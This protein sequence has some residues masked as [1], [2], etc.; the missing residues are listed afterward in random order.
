MEKACSFQC[1]QARTLEAAR[2]AV[3]SADSTRAIYAVP[4]QLSAVWPHWPRFGAI[5]HPD[6]TRPSPPGSQLAAGL[7][8]RPGVLAWHARHPVRRSPPLT[9]RPRRPSGE[10]RCPPLCGPCRPLLERSSCPPTAGPVVTRQ[11]ASGLT[12]LVTQRLRALAARWSGCVT[13][14]VWVLGRMLSGPSERLPDGLRA[15]RNFTAGPTPPSRWSVSVRRRASQGIGRDQGGTGTIH[16]RH[17]GLSAPL[18]QPEDT[19]SCPGLQVSRDPG[20][21]GL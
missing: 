12:A 5:R 13:L 6:P 10:N 11:W 14:P 15:I 21:S 8:R 19:C 3:S 17:A 16:T 1:I 2:P 7:A 20:R 18:H 9:T 4:R